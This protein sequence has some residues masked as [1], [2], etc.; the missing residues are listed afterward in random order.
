M[1][2]VPNE[3]LSR[4]V[5]CRLYSVQF[6]LDYVQLWFDSTRSSDAP[7]V[8]CDVMPHVHR[9]GKRLRD[10]DTGY[11]DVLRTL[12]GEEVAGTAEATGE[13]IRIDFPSGSLVFNPSADEL[14]GPEIAYLR[15][16]NDEAWIVWRPGE[17]SFEHL[18]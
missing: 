9:A 11:A 13:G 14:V 3:L 2:Y 17:D 1:S 8:N 6:V 4:L 12:I 7:L 18:S 10:G 15:G 5:G 16:F